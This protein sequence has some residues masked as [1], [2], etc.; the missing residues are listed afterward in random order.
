MFEKVFKKLTIENPYELVETFKKHYTEWEIDYAAESST[1][2]GF[3][4]KNPNYGTPFIIVSMPKVTT[5]MYNPYSFMA[6]QHVK[7]IL[8]PKWNPSATSRKP[9][10]TK[11]M[12]LYEFK[13]VKLVLKMLLDAVSEIQ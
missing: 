12:R 8:T 7:V 2:Y 4:L 1:E 11:N 9:P 5:P 6:E 3:Y 13:N 10:V